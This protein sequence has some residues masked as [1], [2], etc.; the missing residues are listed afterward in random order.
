MDYQFIVEPGEAWLPTPP[1]SAKSETQVA[2]Q[3]SGI[4]GPGGA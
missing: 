3:D 1:V 2:G 4:T